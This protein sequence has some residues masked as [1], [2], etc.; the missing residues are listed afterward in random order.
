[1]GNAGM[2]G[3]GNPNPAILNNTGKITK[4]IKKMADEAIELYFQERGG[5]DFNIEKDGIIF[6]IEPSYMYEKL[7]IICLAKKKEFSYIK[8]GYA[9]GGWGS[10]ICATTKYYGDYK[11]K[12]KFVK[13]IDK[14]HSTIYGRKKRKTN[15]LPKALCQTT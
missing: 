10:E 15:R 14:Y 8:T 6:G 5:F 12:S 11:Y 9:W 2:T 7:K 1:M 13:F 3:L 4:P